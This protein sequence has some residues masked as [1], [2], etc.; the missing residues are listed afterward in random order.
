LEAGDAGVYSVTWAD[1]HIVGIHWRTA[2]ALQRRGLVTIEGDPMPDEP[3][4]LFLTET[5]RYMAG[6]RYG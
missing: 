4:D 6:G 3:S 5:G 2:Q 1:A